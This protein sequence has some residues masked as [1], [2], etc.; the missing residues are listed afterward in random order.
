VS[1]AQLKPIDLRY[2][3]IYARSRGRPRKKER[4]Q[5]NTPTR[6]TYSRISHTSFAR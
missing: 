5:K 2:P 6:Q 3:I 1:L 4:L